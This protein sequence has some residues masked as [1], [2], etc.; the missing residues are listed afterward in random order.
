MDYNDA[1]QLGIG[2]TQLMRGWA[3]YIK[4]TEPAPAATSI[5]RVIPGDTWERLQV[6]HFTYTCDANAANRYI[7]Y[8]VLDG[9]GNVVIKHSP[10]GTLTAGQT[11]DVT[12]SNTG[13]EHTQGSGTSAAN[14]PDVMLPSGW[15]VEVIVAG[16]KAGDQFSN[17]AFIMQRYP[18][19]VASGDEYQ[20][21]LTVWRQFWDKI[22]GKASA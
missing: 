2:T 6:L 13:T 10:C 20:E 3:E 11:A 12:I 17:V 21:H 9:D 15:T 5:S 7:T 14:V 22:R 18:S 19:D 1:A 8:Q 4:Q 16:A